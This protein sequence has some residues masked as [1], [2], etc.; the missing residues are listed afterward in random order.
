MQCPVIDIADEREALVPVHMP[1]HDHATVIYYPYK[2]RDFKSTALIMLVSHLLAP[3]FF[4]EMRTEKQY[5]YLVNV[6]YIPI[7]RYPGMAF[8]IQSPNV[9]PDILVNEINSFIEHW[10]SKVA[11]IPE[12]QWQ[13]L[14][15]G[16]AGQIMEKDS[17]LRIKSQ[18]FWGAICNHDFQFDH[19]QKMIDTILNVERSDLETLITENQKKPTDIEY[20]NRVTLV[21]TTNDLANFKETTKLSGQIITNCE[22]FTQNCKRKY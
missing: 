18:R 20:R 17:S 6:G 16:L 1:H 2:S 9:E 3:L 22:N 13:Y 8:Y 12:E 11:K 14:K 7:N 15:Q 21:S 19:K 5:G 4:E 10:R